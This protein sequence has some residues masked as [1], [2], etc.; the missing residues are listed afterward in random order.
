MCRWGSGWDWATPWGEMT[1][2]LK[3]RLKVGEGGQPSAEQLL[4][5]TAAVGCRWRQFFWTALSRALGGFSPGGSVQLQDYEM[6]LH[7]Q[8]RNICVPVNSGDLDVSEW[9]CGVVTSAPNALLE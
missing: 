3:L 5:V 9:V 4:D 8:L 1:A 6:P 2:V 7:P